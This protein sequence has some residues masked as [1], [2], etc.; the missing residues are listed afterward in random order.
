MHNLISTDIWS[1]LYFPLLD[2]WRVWHHRLEQHRHWPRQGW[3]FFKFLISKVEIYNALLFSSKSW[4]YCPLFYII[5]IA[6]LTMV[7]I[8]HLLNPLQEPQKSENQVS[9]IMTACLPSSLIK[10]GQGFSKSK[11]IIDYLKFY[12]E[13][14]WGRKAL[15]TPCFQ[16]SGTDCIHLTFGI[17]RE[18]ECIIFS[19]W[20]YVS[21]W[22]ICGQHQLA[23]GKKDG[24]TSA[25]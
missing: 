2:L 18:Y 12:P 16:P 9:H 21:T 23:S 13:V 11:H 19:C 3:P 15:W 4:N 5:I 20:L 25:V 7:F 6:K 22:R 14:P 8:I 10:R 1:P 24:M 17:G